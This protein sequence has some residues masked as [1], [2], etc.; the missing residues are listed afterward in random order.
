MFSIAGFV[1]NKRRIKMPS[2]IKQK[3]ATFSSFLSNE[4]GTVIT[5]FVWTFDSVQEQRVGKALAGQV[6]ELV[7]E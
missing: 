6:R 1:S 4:P 5:F 3:L 7:A 2:C